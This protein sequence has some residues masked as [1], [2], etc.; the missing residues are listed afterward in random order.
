VTWGAGGIDVVVVSGVEF[1]VVAN[2]RAASDSLF[3]LAT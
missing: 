3:R 2:V 1:G